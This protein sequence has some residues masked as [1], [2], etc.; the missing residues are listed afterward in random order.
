[1]KLTSVPSEARWADLAARRCVKQTAQPCGKRA[2]RPIPRAFG[3][4]CSELLYDVVEVS[5][6]VKHYRIDW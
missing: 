3:T 5:F 2:K 1:M 6:D 4:N